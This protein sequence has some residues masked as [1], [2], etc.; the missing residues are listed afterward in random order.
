MNRFELYRI[1]WKK[2]SY[3]YELYLNPVFKTKFIKIEKKNLSFKVFGIPKLTF[4]KSLKFHLFFASPSKLKLK[5][6][7]SKSQTICIKNLNFFNL[8]NDYIKSL[9]DFTFFSKLCIDQSIL[10]FLLFLQEF[11]FRLYMS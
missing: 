4:S 10:L 6:V 7:G 1:Y 9:K 11:Q 5:K 3:Y 8:L 2:I